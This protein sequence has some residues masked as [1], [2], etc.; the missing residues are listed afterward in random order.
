MTEPRK[1]VTD[2]WMKPIPIRQFDWAAYFDGDEPDDDGRMPHGSGTTE[3]EAIA[4][5]VEKYP[6]EAAQ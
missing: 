6:E 3:A 4:D 5:L 1:I 2:F